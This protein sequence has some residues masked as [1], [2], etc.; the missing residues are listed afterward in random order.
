MTKGVRLVVQHWIWRQ[1]AKAQSANATDLLRCIVALDFLFA[2]SQCSLVVKLG[3]VFLGN[4]VF[5]R[6]F[7]DRSSYRSTY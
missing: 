6:G 1:E 5:L 3:K 7:Y 2:S 4:H